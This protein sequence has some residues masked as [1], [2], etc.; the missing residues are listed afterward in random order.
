[1]SEA[2]VYSWRDHL[3]PRPGAQLHLWE[4]EVDQLSP[5]QQE[6]FVSLVMLGNPVRAVLTQVKSDRGEVPPEHGSTS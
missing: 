3:L 4:A 1:M 6:R 2:A 5:E